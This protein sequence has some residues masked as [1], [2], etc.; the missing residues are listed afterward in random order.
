MGIV[1]M[2]SLM[3][4][5]GMRRELGDKIIA[6]FTANGVALKKRAES[7]RSSDAR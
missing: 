4:S 6:G 1:S 5:P 2:N 3:A 7:L